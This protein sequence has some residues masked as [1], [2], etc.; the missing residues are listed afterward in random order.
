M[1]DFQRSF[2]HHP[3]DNPT[4]SEFPSADGSFSPCRLSAGSTPHLKAFDHVC[5]LRYPRVHGARNVRGAL[6]RIRGCV[7]VWHVHAGDGDLGVSLHGVYKCC[8]DLSESDHSKFT[9]FLF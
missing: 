4:K 7:R 8:A 9:A 3:R 5:I 2:P 1:F 6:R